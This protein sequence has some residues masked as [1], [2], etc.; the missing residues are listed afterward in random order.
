MQGIGILAAAAVSIFIT[1]IFQAANPGGPY[2][3]HSVQGIKASVSDL[4]DYVWRIQVS[5]VSALSRQLTVFSPSLQL[6]FGAIPAI[7]TLHARAMM[8]ETSRYTLRVEGDAIKASL[9][10][11]EYSG[12]EISKPIAPPSA[13]PMS[14]RQFLREFWRPLLGCCGAWF[15]LDIAFYSQNLFQKVCANRLY[16]SYTHT[17]D[18]FS[19]IGWIPPASTMNA[20]EEHYHVARAQAIIALASTVPGYFFTVRP[21]ASSGLRRDS[22]HVVSGLHGRSLGQKDHP[23]HGVCINDAVHGGAC[24][25]RSLHVLFWALIPLTRSEIMKIS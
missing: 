15:F 2:D 3:K 23:A 8:P 18:V 6:A 1:L 12:Q 25:V 24:G 19:A 9:D 20:L 14:G 13:P 10:A 17:Q 21:P 16:N 7:L 22:A 4:A 5:R 11:A